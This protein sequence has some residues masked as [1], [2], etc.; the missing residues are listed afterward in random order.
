MKDE[1]L[2]YFQKNT[3]SNDEI[4]FSSNCLDNFTEGDIDALLNSHNEN[5]QLSIPNKDKTEDQ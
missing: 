4:D 5:E 3:V 2:N 1:D